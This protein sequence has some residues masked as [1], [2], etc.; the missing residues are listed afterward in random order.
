MP[1]QSTTS[2][3]LLIQSLLQHPTPTVISDLESGI[4]LDANELFFN[5]THYERLEL[6]G[7]TAETND[8]ITPIVDD[9]KVKNSINYSKHDTPVEQLIQCKNGDVISCLVSSRLIDVNSHKLLITSYQ[10][11]TERLKSKN[12]LETNLLQQTL[13]AEISQM[14]LSPK[15]FNETIQ[16]VFKKIGHHC[17][18]CRIYIFEDSADSLSTSNTFEWCNHNVVSQK[19]ALQNIPYALFPS[20]NQILTNQGNICFSDTTQLPDDI[21]MFLNTQHIKSILVFPLYQ[22]GKRIGFIGFDECRTQRNWTLE[23]K[24][25]LHTTAN[26]I[27]NAF[28]KQR[29]HTQLKES[30]LRLKLALE[31]ANEGIWD[32]NLITDNI[33]F[34]Q[35]YLDFLGVVGR[36]GLHWLELRHYIHPEDRPIVYTRFKN[37]TEG[38]TPYFIS[39]HRLKASD[40]QY[41]WVFS[42]GKVVEYDINNHPLRSLGTCIDITELKTTESK[43]KETLAIKDKIFSI[44]AHDLRGPIQSFIPWL[45][46]ITTERNLDR[47]TE[48]I[49]LADIKK[50][51]IHASHLLDNLLAW[52]N[53]QQND[54][55][56]NADLFPI[57]RSFQHA[58]EFLTGMVKNKSISIII[59]TTEEQVYGD[60][61]IINLVIRN[62]LSNALKFTPVKGT[63]IMS[64]T[65]T[66]DKIHILI[67]DNGIGISPEIMKK[68]TT[69][70]YFSSYGTENEKGS[71]LG[72]NLCKE[73]LQKMGS[74]LIIQST[75]NKGSCFSFYLPLSNKLK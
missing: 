18:A 52:A 23:E 37:H 56:L 49:F 67:K 39:T 47:A 53:S 70:E 3:L 57:A 35:Y 9:I 33:S 20:W 41:H 63:I 73:M 54:I 59:H 16:K 31:G 1:I 2:L 45:E 69:G 13:L 5:L 58:S 62:L 26:I 50:M 24:S 21:Q 30:E 6:I 51:S 72:L 7:K 15:H 42:R 27:S 25:L 61:R 68:I 10:D 8:L 12:R 66:E 55:A 29:I 60:E 44:L 71:G 64:A 17:D 14:L 36:N 74:E 46:L 4:I 75:P 65:T 28:E 43:L 48:N 22:S 40:N 19:I 32:W 11:I 34:N 38:R